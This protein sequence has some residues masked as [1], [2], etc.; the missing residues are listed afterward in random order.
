M[1]RMNVLI[2]TVCGGIAGFLKFYI[3]LLTLRVYLTWFPNLN[4]Y[5]QPLYSLGKMTDPY[6]RVFRGIIPTFIG[7][8]LSPLLGFILL[9]F[10][11]DFFSS[12]AG[13]IS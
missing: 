12:A 11:I 4:F 13:A 8:D 7:L 1:L 9:T 5:T 3:A 6:L 10:L 2:L